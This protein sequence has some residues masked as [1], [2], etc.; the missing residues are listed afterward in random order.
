MPL[1][2]DPQQRKRIYFRFPFLRSGA[3]VNAD[4]AMDLIALVEA[5][6][7]STL[8]A[9]RATDFEVCSFLAMVISE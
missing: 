2:G 8:L 3:C 4:A 5:G 9:F 6:S 7:A 1:S